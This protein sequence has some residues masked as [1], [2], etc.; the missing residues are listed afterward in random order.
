MANRLAL[1]TG[2]NGGIGTEICK[3]LAG[4]G[5]K[6]VTTCVDAEKEN[7]AGWQA[8]RKAE[9]FDIDYVECNVADF[10]SCAAMAKQVEDKHGPVEVLVNV[11]GITKDAFLHKMEPDA[12]NAVLRVNLDSVFNVTRQFV[13]G[14]R[15][16]GFG[17]VVNIASVNGQKGQFG[18]A[19]YAAAKAG[20]HGF[21]MS[22][23]QEGARKGVTCNT[24]CPGYIETAMTAKIPE[25]VLKGIVAQVPAGRMG[26]PEEIARTVVFLAADEAEYINGAVIP[27]N[28]ALFTSF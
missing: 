27:V 15:S 19:N 12:W 13:D 11:A 6:V 23:A 16:R 8:E 22:L 14:M 25:E 2:G 7:I 28:G 26:K 5:Y 9:G 4:A 1:V 24:V 20:M 10:D 3:Q 17:R 21:T 18:Q